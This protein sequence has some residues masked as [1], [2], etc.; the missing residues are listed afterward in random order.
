MLGEDEDEDDAARIFTC[1]FP[2]AKHVSVMDANVRINEER[3][4]R[5]L[6]YVLRRHG[7]VREVGEAAERARFDDGGC[8]EPRR[9]RMRGTDGAR[10]KRALLG[11]RPASSVSVDSVEGVG[12]EVGGRRERREE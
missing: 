11:S 8:S 7:E 10:L 9:H 6:Q 3:Y 2:V 5:H 12:V 1:I 4:V